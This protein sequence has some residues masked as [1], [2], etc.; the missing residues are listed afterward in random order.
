[1]GQ[2]VHF[3][4]GDPVTIGRAFETQDFETLEDR[5]AIPLF[6]D[7]SLHLSPIDF[8]LMTEAIR[9]LVGDGPASLTDSLEHSVAASDDGSSADIV[10]P[11]W[12]SM[13]AGLEDNWLEATIAA[14][15]GAM[16]KEYS[17]PIEPTDDMRRAL[18][19][20]IALCRESRQRNMPVVLTWSL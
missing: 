13:V 7:F 16:A 4:A 8:D 15:T 11:G 19:E 6:S 20:L 14:W 18:R 2:L 17:E 3:Y 12:V 1:M 5:A 10:S 9:S